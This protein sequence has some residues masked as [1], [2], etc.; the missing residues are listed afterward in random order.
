MA[1]DKAELHNL[2]NWIWWWESWKGGYAAD[3]LRRGIRAHRVAVRKPDGIMLN[4]MLE[5]A[6]LCG[7]PQNPEDAITIRDEEVTCEQ[8]KWMVG[9][10]TAADAGP[11]HMIV[12]LYECGCYW[13]IFNGL[14]NGTGRCEGFNSGHHGAPVGRPNVSKNPTAS[15]R[16]AYLRELVSRG[17]AATT[18]DARVLLDDFLRYPWYYRKTGTRGDR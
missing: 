11:P 1:A 8:C 15:E 9:M 12:E 6:P 5:G 18:A 13:S 3:Y 7:Q 16:I 10:A 4:N 17:W 2:V 14:G